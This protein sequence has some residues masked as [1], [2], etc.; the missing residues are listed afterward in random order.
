[1]AKSENLSPD[2]GR[3][4]ESYGWLKAQAP[5]KKRRSPGDNPV[6]CAIILVFCPIIIGKEWWKNY[7][8]NKKTKS[9]LNIAV[10]AV[11][12][13]GVIDYEPKIL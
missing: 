12:G 10:H 13:R 4:V 5:R 7:F 3:I 1:V 9:D 11:N 8:F 2:E 6:Q